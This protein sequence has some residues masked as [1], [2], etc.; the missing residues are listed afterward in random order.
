MGFSK[1][2]DKLQ[3]NIFTTFRF[4][5][6]DRDGE[7]G[8]VVKV[9][10]HPRY[11]DHEFIGE[12]KIINKEQRAM[13]WDGDK[14]GAIKITN[15]ETI[16]DGFKNGLELAYFSM[17]EFMREN[18]GGERLLTEPMNKLTLEWI[19]KNAQTKAN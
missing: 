1:K 8:E 11:I 6:K 2:W 4:I 17:W 13:A 10:Y 12:A 3:Q 15:G 18:Y 16:A 14:T 19:D 9:V 7:I 5:R